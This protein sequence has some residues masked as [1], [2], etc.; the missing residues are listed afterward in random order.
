MQRVKM[1][2]YFTNMSMSV[3]ANLPPL[4]FVTFRSL[5]GISYSLLGL[6]IAVN[7]VTQLTIDLIFSFFSHKFDIPKVVKLTPVLT[8]LG[9]LIFAVFPFFF[10]EHAY[11]FILTGTIIFS[12]SSGLS[13]V[14]ISP[15]VAAIPSKDPDKQ[16]SALHS[17]YA[18]GIVGVV[19]FSTLFLH[20]FGQYCWQIL[21]IVLC[22]VPII[23]AILYSNAKIPQIDTPKS[24]SG[25]LSFLRQ[26]GVW[27]C[28]FS[29]FLGGAAECTMSQWCSPYLEKAL[30]IP[31]IYG[32]VFGVALFAL[33]LGLGRSLYA[34]WGKNIYKVL[35]FCA[36]GATL[37][38][39]TAAVSLHPTIGLIA[40]VLTGFFT[41]M[42]WPGNIIIAS[43]RFP[44]SGVLIYA[45]MAAG[46]DLGA[47][48]AP[49][50]VGIIT[51]T[52]MA[53]PSFVTLALNLGIT[54]EQFGMKLGML[55]AMLFPLIAIFLYAYMWKKSK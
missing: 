30:N 8:I 50:A 5:Y 3:V 25:A 45:L 37:C 48:V 47:S 26:G 39:G 38:Y 51:D 13:E 22:I 55:C 11:L 49:Q 33:F 28:V 6:L 44:E 34:K 43:E 42:L 29:I 32:D 12:A 16:M 4:L 18:W 23:A 35:F 2:C 53:N 40:C 41:S 54:T 1:G 7:F 36:L 21:A 46:G 9:L 52:V 31:K 17:V 24:S 20:I 15:V 27:L 19:I 14:L 10:K